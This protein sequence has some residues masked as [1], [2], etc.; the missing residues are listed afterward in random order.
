MTPRMGSTSLSA[1]ASPPIMKSSSPFF[2][3]QSPPVTGASRKCTPRSA[4]AAAILRASAG[5]TVLEAAYVLPRFSACKAPFELH[6]TSSSAGGSLT[7]VRR[8][9]EAAATSCGDFASFAPAATSSSAREAVRFHT[10]REYPALMRFMPMGRPIKPSPINPIF[11]PADDS[12][13]GLLELAVA[14]QACAFL[15]KKEDTI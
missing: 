14:I 13:G 15:T 11:L 12:K 4:Q 8:K 10:E 6:K 9:S 7:M 5:Q 2:A 3:P 1:P